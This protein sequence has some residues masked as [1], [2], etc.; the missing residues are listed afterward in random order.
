M[1]DVEKM[2]WAALSGAVLTV[3]WPWMVAQ[4]MAALTLPIRPEKTERD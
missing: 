2:T 1:N 3:F 4:K